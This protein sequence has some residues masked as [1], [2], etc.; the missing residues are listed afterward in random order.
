MKLQLVLTLGVILVSLTV[1]SEAAANRTEC[2]TDSVTVKKETQK[3]YCA[4]TEL[5]NKLELVS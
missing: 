4:A 5:Y 3:F 1:K 2:A